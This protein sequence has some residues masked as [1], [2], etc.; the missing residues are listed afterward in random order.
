MAVAERLGWPHGVPAARAGWRRG[1]RRT[2]AEGAARAD[3][4]GSGLDLHRVLVE[5]MC[6]GGYDLVTEAME[7]DRADAREGSHHA[8]ERELR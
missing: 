1:G 6:L 5:A 3:V 8:D 2:G 7:A 4:R